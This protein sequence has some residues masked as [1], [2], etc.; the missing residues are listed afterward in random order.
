[1]TTE[2]ERKRIQVQKRKFQ[3]EQER[4]IK[5]G[6]C[7]KYLTAVIAKNLTSE[8]WGSKIVEKLNSIDIETEITQSNTA[9]TIKWKRRMN[10]K[11]ISDT[12]DVTQFDD[13]TKDE[14]YLIIILPAEQFVKFSKENKLLSQIQEAQQSHHDTLKSS[15]LI[16]YGLKDFCRKRK[17]VIGIKETEIKLTQVQLFANCSHRLH[18]TPDDVALTVAQFSKSIAEEPFKYVNT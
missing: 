14:N 6:E 4:C 3:L 15:T 9:N 18:E 2:K 13:I 8:I 5:P 17:G 1:M 7:N 10:Q 12:G 16:V 11:I